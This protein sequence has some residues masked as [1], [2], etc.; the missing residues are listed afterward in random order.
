LGIPAIGISAR[1]LEGLAQVFI[2]CPAKLARSAS[3]INPADADPIPGFAAMS[4]SC[5]SEIYLMDP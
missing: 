1:S 4:Q 3:R 2:A 5:K